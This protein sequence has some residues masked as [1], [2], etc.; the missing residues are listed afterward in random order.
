MA[1]KEQKTGG[2]KKALN[3]NK[4]LKDNPTIDREVFGQ[5]AK[6]HEQL[7]Q[8]GFKKRGYRL[9]TR[10]IRPMD[11]DAESDGRTVHLRKQG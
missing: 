11:A 2:M 10:S 1:T 3:V 4:I 9:H 7:K 5:A 6:M 8:S